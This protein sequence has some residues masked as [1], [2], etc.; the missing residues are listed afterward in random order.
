MFA[1]IERKFIT[2]TATF[3]FGDVVTVER[4]RDGYYTIRKLDGARAYDVPPHMLRLR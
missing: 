2:S 4:Q 1:T 3:S